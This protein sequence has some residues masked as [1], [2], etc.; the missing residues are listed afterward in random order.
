MLIEN[1]SFIPKRISLKD[2]ALHKS[3]GVGQVETWYYEGIFKNNYSIVS[4][5]N[6]FCF[7]KIGIVLTGLFI[8]KDN[9][10]V[11]NIRNRA[12][13]RYFN[14]S[15]EKLL[16]VTNKEPLITVRIENDPNKWD[17]KVVMGD[18]KNGFDLN[19]FNAKK[20]WGGNQYLGR[21]IVVPRSEIKGILYHEGKKIDVT[22]EG[23]HDHNI[24]PFYKPLF[25][26]GVNWGKIRTE[27]FNIVWAWV[28][29]NSKKQEYICVINKDNEFF[30]IPSQDVNLSVKSHIKKHRKIVP[31]K[32]N[33]YVKKNDIL[34]DIDIE[35]IDCHFIKIPSVK[36]WRHHAHNTGEIKIGN[37]SEKV[38]DVEII[39]QLSFL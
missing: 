32:Y 37:I 39:D 17:C 4:L 26:K 35:S 12:S 9:K 6:I 11:K 28:M 10:L 15:E 8:Y 38:D 30:S 20:P 21:W 33:I 29:K 7:R 16:I 5:V 27:S 3:K 1:M 34:I 2:D 31:T 18:K 36:Y 13:L 19:F 24:Y 25:N 22:G 23:Y 14:V